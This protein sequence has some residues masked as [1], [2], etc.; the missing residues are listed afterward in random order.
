MAA[1]TMSKPRHPRGPP[2][3]T[4]PTAAAVPCAQPAA[5]SLGAPYGGYRMVNDDVIV[6]VEN[7]AFGRPVTS[8]AIIP[9]PQ[10]GGQVYIEP[11]SSKVPYGRPLDGNGKR[12]RVS[13]SSNVMA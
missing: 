11:V 4:P 6:F 12:C 5:G 13:V 3:V 8:G 10:G 2:R 7:A 9:A 1:A